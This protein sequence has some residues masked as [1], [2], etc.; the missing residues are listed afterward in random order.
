MGVV[1]TL[2]GVPSLMG[3]RFIECPRWLGPEV[4]QK[5]WILPCPCPGVP[6]GLWGQWAGKA[7]D[8]GQREKWS[9]LG[10]VKLAHGGA[11]WWLGSEELWML[12]SN[13][14][15]SLCLGFEGNLRPW[16]S[17]SASLS[18]RFLEES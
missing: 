17:P 14:V 11:G 4:L 5:A 16:A 13:A 1:S 12:W 8:A 7:N 10:R 2:A 9:L 3:K 6:P 18:L 15:V